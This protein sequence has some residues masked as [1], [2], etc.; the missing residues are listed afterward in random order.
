MDG[1]ASRT[2]TLL[3][4]LED[5]TVAEKWKCSALILISR[6]EINNE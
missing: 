2:A 4:V 3:T 5:L 6:R 1:S